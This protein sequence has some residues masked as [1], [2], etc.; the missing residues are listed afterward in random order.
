MKTNRTLGY[1]VKVEP[2]R[3]GTFHGEPKDQEQVCQAIKEGIERH[4]DS[5]SN[6]EIV[7]ES[8]DVCSFCGRLWTENNDHC[9][10]GCCD[11]DAEL[12]PNYF[13]EN[14]DARFP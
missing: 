5:Y 10:G 2:G 7:R 12:Y 4:V 3:I 13:D 14:G 9:N 11:E 6:V 8:E 1:H